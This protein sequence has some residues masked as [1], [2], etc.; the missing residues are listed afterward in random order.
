MPHPESG[1]IPTHR[2]SEDPARDLYNYWINCHIGTAFNMLY[3]AEAIGE[4]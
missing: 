2:M 3:L 4:A 1:V